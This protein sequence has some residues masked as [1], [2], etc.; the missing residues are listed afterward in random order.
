LGFA[1]WQ[2]GLRWLWVSALVVLLDV[3][4]KRL[5]STHLSLHEAIVVTP[6]FNVTLA[7]NQGAAFSFL[8]DAGG[9]QRWLLIGLALVVSVMLLIWLSR[10]VAARWWTGTALA[11]IFGGA[12]GNVW[13]RIQH[14]YVVDFIQVY[15]QDW[16]FPSFNIADSAISVGAVMLLIESIRKEN[17]NHSSPDYR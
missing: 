5:V 17:T 1:I 3:V 12:A 4:T 10:L 15:Y 6:F 2:S 13:D 9:W 8:H 11:M 16:Y 7:H 14:G